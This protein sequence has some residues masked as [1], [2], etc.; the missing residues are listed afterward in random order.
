MTEKTGATYRLPNEA[1]WRH[2]AGATG[3]TFDGSDFNCLLLSGGSTVKGGAPVPVNTAPQ[4]DWGLYN[5]V[6]NAQEWI[7]A[8]S[9]SMVSGGHYNDPSGTCSIT[10]VRSHGS[11]GDELTGF[12]LLREIKL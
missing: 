3:N 10:L 5:Y 2:A 8:S 7:V 12:R 1:E 4:N 11:S 9:G 6:G